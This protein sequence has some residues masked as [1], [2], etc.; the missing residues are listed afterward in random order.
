M[1]LAKHGELR[2]FFFFFFFF[3]FFYDVLETNLCLLR[4]TIVPIYASKNCM[5]FVSANVLLATFFLSSFYF[6]PKRIPS[7]ELFL[8]ITL[9][10]I[11]ISLEREQF[12]T[13]RSLI[14]G[15]SKK[16]R[17]RVSVSN[18]ISSY[19]EM[20]AS[21]ITIR[22]EISSRNPPISRYKSANESLVQPWPAARRSSESG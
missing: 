21:S 14:I 7:G 19:I 5:D 15:D 8:I 16:D 3:F 13:S 22:V 12:F 20:Y 10:K 9:L 11:S 4:G 6:N 1:L 2:V 17:V 18:Y